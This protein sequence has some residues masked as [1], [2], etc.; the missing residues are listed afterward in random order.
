LVYL[1][2]CAN[3]NSVISTIQRGDLRGNEQ[4]QALTLCTNLPSR[5]ELCAA[6][7]LGDTLWRR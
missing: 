3:S 1:S 2:E 5:A 4:G 7:P 6:G